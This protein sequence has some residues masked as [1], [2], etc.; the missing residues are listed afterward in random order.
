[1]IPTT[2]L[3]RNIVALEAH[4]SRNPAAPKFRQQ[5][6]SPLAAP[7]LFYAYGVAGC[8]HSVTVKQPEASSRNTGRYR[9]QLWTDTQPPSDSHGP[10]ASPNNTAAYQ[11]RPHAACRRGPQ[12][13]FPRTWV[14]HYPLLKNADIWLPTE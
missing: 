6:C 9:R 3:L 8:G 1:M 14:Y 10:L 7:R 5:A 11:A 4:L 12:I 13:S 2:P